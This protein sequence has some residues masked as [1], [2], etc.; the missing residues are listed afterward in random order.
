LGNPE[1]DVDDD[2]FTKVEYDG[3]GSSSNQKEAEGLGRG[4]KKRGLIKGLKT[5][6][7][8][9]KKQWAPKIN[10][11]LLYVTASLS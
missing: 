10:E 2:G 8:E 7:E 3:E 6:L 5:K 1:P 4:A 11:K 9:V